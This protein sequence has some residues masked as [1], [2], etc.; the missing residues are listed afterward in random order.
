MVLFLFFQE[1][2]GIRD[3]VRSRGLGDVYKRQDQVRITLVI[4]A[5]ANTPAVA[6]ELQAMGIVIEGAYQDLIDIAVPMTLIE[7]FAQ[8]TDAGQLFERLTQ[9]DHIL[10]LR[11]P[12]P[13]QV[14]HGDLR[15]PPEAAPRPAPALALKNI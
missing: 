1:E 7:Q 13:T 3:L 9:L 14:N 2:D 11:L 8:T 6:A 5:A 10:K 15:T 12:L 4:D